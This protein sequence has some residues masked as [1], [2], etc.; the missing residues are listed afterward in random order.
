MGRW[1]FFSSQF[2]IA[3]SSLSQRSRPLI[4]Q[5]LTDLASAH[6]KIWKIYMKT[7]GAFYLFLYLHPW[8]LS[9]SVLETALMGPLQSNLV[10]WFQA[11]ASGDW[12]ACSH[13]EQLHEL[14]KQAPFTLWPSVSSSVQSRPQTRWAL[15]FPSG[16]AFYAVLG[17][18]FFVPKL[19][20]SSQSMCSGF[21]IATL[22]SGCTVPIFPVGWPWLVFCVEVWFLPL[23]FKVPP[24]QR[25]NLW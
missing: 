5:Q 8:G 16:P 1:D 6:L 25:K 2:G 21:E 23:G 24:Y 15:R 22:S 18:I 12:K 17:R 9:S 10:G 13:W 11:P 14:G 7:K 19:P 3:F 4:N 20:V